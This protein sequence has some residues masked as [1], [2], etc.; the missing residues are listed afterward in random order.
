MRPTL[1]RQFASSSRKTFVNEPDAEA[2]RKIKA[3]AE[4]AAVAKGATGEAEVRVGLEEMNFGKLSP[5][6][7]PS[8]SFLGLKASDLS[9]SA[10]ISRG[11]K[12]MEFFKW[13]QWNLYTSLQDYHHRMKLFEKG[14]WKTEKEGVPGLKWME[15]RKASTHW[16]STVAYEKYTALQKAIASGDFKSINKLSTHALKEASDSQAKT[17]KLDRDT[18]YDWKVVRVI[19]P[20]SVLSVRTTNVMPML[21]ESA[22]KRICQVVVKF[23]TVQSLGPNHPEHN[24]LDYVMF[25][26]PLWMRNGDWKM[27]DKV[28]ETPYF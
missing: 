6:V 15:R 4:R 23:N 10:L 22:E 26:K 17:V 20:P 13:L 19:E 16:A 11:F 24:V 28:Y 1:A 7:K 21:P 18:K 5:Y 9:P 12:P 2:L 27:R 3:A 14:E 25:E 8:R